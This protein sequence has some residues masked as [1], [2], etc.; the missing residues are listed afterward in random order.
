MV[1]SISAAHVFSISCEED[2]VKFSNDLVKFQDL[3]SEVNI[4]LES[5][6]DLQ[7]KIFQL[8]PKMG[9]LGRLFKKLELHDWCIK[10]RKFTS[11]TLQTSIQDAK[12]TLLEL[13]NGLLKLR[14]NSLEQELNQNVSSLRSCTDNLEVRDMNSAHTSIKLS[15]NRVRIVLL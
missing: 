2:A 6:L 5:I 13:E 14:V 10:K 9:E 8:K 12:T 15:I 1:K 3:A 7:T 11:L 4:G